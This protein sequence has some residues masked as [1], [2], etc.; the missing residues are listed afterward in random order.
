M[1]SKKV[2]VVANATTGSV[3]N[4]SENNPDYAYVRLEQKR[5]FI[6]D[7]GF[8]KPRTVSTLI[9]GNVEDLRD[10]EF[11]A[12]QELEGNIQVKE[13]LEPFSSKYPDRDLKV[14]GETGIVCTQGGSPI[15]RKTVYDPTGTKTDQPVQHDN[16]EE[17]RAA[18]E[19]QQAPSAMKPNDE[20]SIGG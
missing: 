20:F 12:G 3:I 14:A 5:P 11:F 17:L 16:I 8:L 1:T 7:N 15:Y 19:A 10:M 6:D 18:Y 4:V 13:S 9:Q 2:K